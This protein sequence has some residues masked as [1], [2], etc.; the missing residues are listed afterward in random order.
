MIYSPR[1]PLISIDVSLAPADKG[2]RG[3]DGKSAEAEGAADEVDEEM[4]VASAASSA[5]AA[6][7][8][9]VQDDL[10]RPILEAFYSEPRVSS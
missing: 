8:I 4:P 10:V 1:S 2:H 7:R 9:V 6:P 3:R 5:Q